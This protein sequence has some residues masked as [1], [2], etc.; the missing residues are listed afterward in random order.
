MVGALAR[1][2]LGQELRKDVRG[3][4]SPVLET[5]AN[6]LPRLLGFNLRGRGADKFGTLVGPRLR[7]RTR[8]S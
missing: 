8:V 2:V 3:D 4:R 7:S 1:H 5:H 6:W